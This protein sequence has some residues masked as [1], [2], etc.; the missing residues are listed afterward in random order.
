MK[1]CGARKGEYIAYLGHDDLWFP[2][3]LSSLAQTMEHSNADFVHGA[4]VDVW[5]S[6]CAELHGSPYR[7]ASYDRHFVPPSGWLHR[8]DIV[9][10]IG[11]WPNPDRVLLGVDFDFQRRAFRAGLRFAATGTLSVVKFRSEKWGLLSLASKPPQPPYLRLIERCPERLRDWVLLEVAF[12][13]SV[14]E[15]S[16][17]EALR[18]LVRLAVNA[19]GRERWPLRPLYSWYWHRA[20]KRKRML[21]G[22]PHSDG[23]MTLPSPRDDAAAPAP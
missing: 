23:T 13:Q 10:R 15:T 21:R 11:Y 5:P 2:W 16:W 18:S 3:H 17:Q 19:I 14:R 12:R 9:D 6:G 22:M 20:R 1:V 4:I 8:R 7:R